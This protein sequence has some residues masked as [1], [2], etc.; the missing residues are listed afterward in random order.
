[1]VGLKVDF[2]LQLTLMAGSLY[3]LM[4]RRIGKEYER[5]QP[6]PFIWTAQAS[7]ILEKVK[8]RPEGA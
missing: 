5:R 1:M 2:D 6:K 3:R 7:D 8:A 4:A